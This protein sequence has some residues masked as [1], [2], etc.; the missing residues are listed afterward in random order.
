M[1]SSL[2]AAAAASAAADKG[3]EAWSPRPLSAESRLIRDLEASEMKEDAAGCLAS[4]DMLSLL[5]SELISRS[6][7]KEAALGVKRALG[8]CC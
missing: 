7:E 5:V 3:C 2:A 6:I 4:S 8:G 1:L